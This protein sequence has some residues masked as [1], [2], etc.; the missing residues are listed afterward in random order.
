MSDTPE[1][2]ASEFPVMTWPSRD[3]PLVVRSTL[4]RKLER[5]RDAARLDRDAWKASSAQYHETNAWMDVERSKYIAALRE[6]AP[7][8]PILP[9]KADVEARREED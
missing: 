2:D 8:H 4:A 5:E 1:T 9:E 6:I 3:N 7:T